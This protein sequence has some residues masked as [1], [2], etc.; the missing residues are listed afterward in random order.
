MVSLY[1]PSHEMLIVSSFLVG[2]F[3]LFAELEPISF[4]SPRRRRGLD[5]FHL[6]EI[7]VE[8]TI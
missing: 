3:D 2:E 5:H 6:T 8:L 1:L 4:N 7:L